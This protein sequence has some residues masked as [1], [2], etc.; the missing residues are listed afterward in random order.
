[1]HRLL[2]SIQILRSMVYEHFD[3][4]QTIEHIH[5]SAWEALAG[6]CA[7]SREFVFSLQTLLYNSLVVIIFDYGACIW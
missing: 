7:R 6:M 3:T 1:M 4:N 5:S 2:Q